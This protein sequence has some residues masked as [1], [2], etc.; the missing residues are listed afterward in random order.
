M[1][2]NAIDERVPPTAVLLWQ[3]GF[4]K[5]VQVVMAIVGMASDDAV[6][7]PS[8]KRL[9]VDIEELRGKVGDGVNQAADLISSTASIPSLNFTP[10]MT[11]GNWF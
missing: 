2:G 7:G 11:F 6:F 1:S 3:I 4:G 10:L 8:D 5:V 9:L